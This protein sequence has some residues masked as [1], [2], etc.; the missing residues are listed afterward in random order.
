MSPL[1]AADN[2]DRPLARALLSNPVWRARYL[3]HVRTITRNW[4]D[5]DKIGPVFRKYQKLIDADVKRDRKRLYGYAE[6]NSAVDG[7]SG[8]RSPRYY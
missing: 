1:V 6:F 2:R 3:A 5:W 8:S 7:D 4:M